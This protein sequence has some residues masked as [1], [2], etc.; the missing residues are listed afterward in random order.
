MADVF[1]KEK[2]SEIMANIRSTN[3]SL[4]TS[5]CKLLSAEVYPMGL[6]YRRNYKNLPGRP[7]IVF[8]KNKLAIFL[9]GDF[10]H[11]YNFKLNSHRLPKKYWL[12]KI[13]N[14]IA[15]DKKINRELKKQGW[16]VVRAWE[17]DIKASP[18]KVLLKILKGLDRIQGSSDQ[19]R[20][21]RTDIRA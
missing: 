4:E 13:Q 14:N 15:R 17:H 7:D 3:T 19:K 10:W 5:F 2:R 18:K 16:Q 8:I 12:Q 1:T 9:D 6:R 21:N 11:G 20:T